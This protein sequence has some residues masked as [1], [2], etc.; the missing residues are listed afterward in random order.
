M[1]TRRKNLTLTHLFKQYCY[2]AECEQADISEQEGFRSSIKSLRVY[3]GDIYF[4]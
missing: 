3:I 1:H 4:Y 2:L